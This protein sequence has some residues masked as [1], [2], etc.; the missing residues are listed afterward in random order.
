MPATRAE[1]RRAGERLLREVVG[2]VSVSRI[3][4]RCA[5][6]LHGRPVVRVARGVAPS[7]S[8]SYADDLVLVAWTW[9]GVIG[10]DVEPAGPPVGEFGEFGDRQRWTLVEAAAKATG[11][12]LRR[13]PAD[14]PV[15]W[16]RPLDLGPTW[17]ATVAVAGVDPRAA[18]V[19]VSWRTAGQ[20]APAR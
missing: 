20:A 3:C 14:L 4:P 8:L 1:L 5:S 16:S 11:E 13:E 15:L 9:A 10:V 12:G 18:G 7:V 17:V 2:A 6:T 19:E